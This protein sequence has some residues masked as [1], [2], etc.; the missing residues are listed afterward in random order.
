MR[1][2]IKLIIRKGKFS[3]DGKHTI[4]I[5]YCYTSKKRV[6]ISTGITI[7]YIYWDKN[8]CSVR[9]TLP[10]EHGSSETLQRNLDQQY[11]KAE[12]IIKYAETKS[13]GCPMQLL[14][15]NFRL[16]DC[17]ELD[18]LED[19]NNSLSVFHQID[20]YIEDKKPM[21]Q[22]GTIT[23]YR[24]MKK[25]LLA[26]QNH[27]GYKLTFDSFNAVLYEQLVHYLTFEIPITRRA[28]IV[29]GL[30]MNTVGKT[31][32]QLKIFIKDRI[33]K[34]IIPY[35]DLTCFKCLEEDVESVFLNWRELSKIYR[36]ELSEN[37]W[38]VKYRDI[39]IVG[40]LT[41]FRFSD[42]S[43][44]NIDHLQDGMLHVRQ[45]KT[46]NP[47][48]VPLREDTRHILIDKYDMR[49]PKVS[50]ENFNLYIKEVVKLACID[51]PV[52]ISYKRGNQLI[53]ETR[54]KYAWVSSLTA[55][56]SFCTNEYLAG[57]PS[58][59]IMAV[60]GH[61]TEKA[62]KKYIKVDHIKKARMI[63]KLWENQPG[64]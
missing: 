35:I 18:Q 44:L 15:R 56:R 16:P 60:S 46:G 26:F 39:F 38:L 54:P 12:K 40:C 49:L 23:V 24:A 36:L 34:K 58:D 48:V 14:K 59:L 5:Q 29:K 30:R 37:P 31:I 7:P 1:K 53:E 51:E 19:A 4:F 64:L 13:L 47:V 41:G 21:V 43:T 32:K 22:S 9:P 28:K 17:W 52:K 8:T 2:K 33:R 50:M 11:L 62:F 10:I 61:K 57:T 45:Y 6:V 3:K 42:Y 25:H 20:R 55:R 27:I 63:K